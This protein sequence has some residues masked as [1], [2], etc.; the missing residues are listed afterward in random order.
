MNDVISE[1]LSA[2]LYGKHTHV[3]PSRTLKGLT[4]DMARK[5]PKGHKYSCWE[6]L[7]HM[8]VWQDFALK[9]LEGEKVKWSDASSIEWPSEERMVEDVEFDRLVKKF[10]KGLKTMKKAIQ[11]IDLEMPAPGL[12]TMSAAHLVL[13]V[14]QHN[15]Y[16]LGQIVMNREALGLWPPISTK[17]A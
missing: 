11:T 12:P 10:K 3:Q 2:G 8:V 6:L 4:A 5:T 13:M 1:M 17:S 15:S 9:N 7:H 16:H 14:L